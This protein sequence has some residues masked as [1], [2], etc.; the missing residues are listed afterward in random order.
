MINHIVSRTR[1]VKDE[2]D[3]HRIITDEL[4]K[5]RLHFS[6]RV[7]V[8]QQVQF[9]TKW[10]HIRE[11]NVTRA[12]DLEKNVS[13]HRTHARV[14]LFSHI[15]TELQ[16]HHHWRHI[17]CPITHHSRI[18]PVIAELKFYKF[19]L[20]ARH[21]TLIQK[22]IWDLC[23]KAVC[24][25]FNPAETLRIIKLKSQCEVKSTAVTIF[26]FRLADC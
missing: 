7:T 23:L 21:S 26:N 8:M 20:V 18:I 15:F 2:E 4:E 9:D 25:H 24:C 22:K 3:W 19:N 10:R 6:R 14:T 12:W 1:M 11:S 5:F 17:T 16:F 13:P